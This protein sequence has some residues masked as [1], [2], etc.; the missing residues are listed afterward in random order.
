MK[1]DMKFD[2][3]LETMEFETA[4]QKR[5]HDKVAQWMDTLFSDV[6]WEPLDQEPGF[7]LFMG[8]ALAEVHIY[9]WGDDDSVVNISSLVV[10]GADLS[11]DLQTFLLQEND[12]LRFGAFALNEAGD[13]LF[14][15]TI[16][17]STC[18]PTELEASVREVLEIADDYDDKI[19]ARWG[20]QRELDR[21]PQSL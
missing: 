5:C 15:H 20:G 6:P 17:G 12:Q 11:C 7:S 4:A 19:V 14:Q 8:S 10:S 1:F 2:M 9:P 21:T 3:E 16:V 18:D 13:V